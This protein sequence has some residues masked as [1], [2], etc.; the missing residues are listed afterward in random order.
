[1]KEL[2]NFGGTNATRVVDAIHNLLEFECQ[3]FNEL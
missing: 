1:M 3:Q 2:S